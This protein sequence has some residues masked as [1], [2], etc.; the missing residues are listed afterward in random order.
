MNLISAFLA[1]G[2]PATPTYSGPT[3]PTFIYQTGTS[4]TAIINY[5]DSLNNSVMAAQTAINALTA[6][7]SALETAV[8]NGSFAAFAASQLAQVS[9]A[10]SQN[11]IIL[12]TAAAYS[13]ATAGPAILTAATAQWLTPLATALATFQAANTVA[14]HAA[15]RI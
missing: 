10:A 6:N 2:A 4:A 3:L 7:L 12:Q 13:L 5:W 15:K 9:D 8:G 14:L 11:E 1:A